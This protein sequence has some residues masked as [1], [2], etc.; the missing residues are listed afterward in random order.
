M[1]VLNFV[2]DRR[3]GL[4]A[5]AAI[6]GVGLAV[7]GGPHCP[8]AHAQLTVFDAGNYAQNALTAARALQQINNQIQALQNQT[9]MLANM[10][11]NLKQASFPEV[12]RLTQSLTAI[13]KL[14]GQGQGITF[15]A[16]DLDGQFDRLFPQS[17]PTDTSSAALAVQAKAR[18]DAATAAFR[19]TMQVQSE[20]VTAV[21]DDAPTLAAL[22]A[23]SQGAQ[24]GLEAAQ[25]TNQLLALASKQ[26]FQIQ[27]LIAAQFRAQ[28][29]ER[30]ARAQSASDA[31]NATRRFI[32]NG[33]IY[34][35]Q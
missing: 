7:V 22:I 28:A 12:E 2:R 23:R 25:V 8:S 14:M 30:Q 1:T 11:R 29:I 27:N 34:T 4:A 21:Q 26:Q 24:G 15:K 17:P 35:P 31:R 13:D 9:T 33:H 3:I 20:I 16:G 5:I 32:G 18:L 6:G 19:Q 10:A